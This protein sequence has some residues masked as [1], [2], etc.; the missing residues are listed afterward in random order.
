MGVV[1]IVFN[2]QPKFKGCSL[3][4]RSFLLTVGLCV[5]YDKLVWSFFLTAEIQCGL[6]CLWWQIGLVFFTC[7]SPR[8][9]IGYG[10]AYGLPTVSKK[11]TVSR[12]A[13]TVSKEDA[14]YL[15]NRAHLNK[16]S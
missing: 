16:F 13:S 11:R 3:S 14:P 6:L 9:E 2:N 1:A 10:F 12:R 8:P 7:S 4:V 15:N 5:A